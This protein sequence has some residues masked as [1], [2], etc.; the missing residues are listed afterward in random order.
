MFNSQ[1][2]MDVAWGSGRFWLAMVLVVITCGLSDVTTYSIDMFFTGRITGLLRILVK[3]KGSLNNA[4]DLPNAVLNKLALYD[5][6]EQKIN[7]DL[8]EKEKSHHKSLV[9][10]L[11]LEKID[12]ISMN[13]DIINKESTP[14]MNLSRA[15]FKPSLV[16]E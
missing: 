11:D 2:T 4:D 13:F 7:A 14:K 1:G 15:G 16:G 6:Y 12:A 10:T 8:H 5:Q 3:Q 9:N